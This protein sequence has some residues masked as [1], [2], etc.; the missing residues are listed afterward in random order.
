MEE[1][2]L[3]CYFNQ[4]FCCGNSDVTKEHNKSPTDAFILY[5]SE[6]SILDGTI[7]A[8]GESNKGSYSLLLLELQHKNMHS[9]PREA[10]ICE[11]AR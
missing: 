5:S 8:E 9:A 10:N 2:E 4:E 7:G 6:T 3:E 11:N 1:I